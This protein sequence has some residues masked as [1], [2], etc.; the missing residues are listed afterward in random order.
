MR[1]RIR[2]LSETEKTAKVS[3]EVQQLRNFEESLLSNYKAYIA[4]LIKVI[5]TSRKD[6]R[7]A[8]L[9]LVA[10]TCVTSLLTNVPHFNFRTD[11]LK[12]I[13]SELSRRT[14]SEAFTKSREALETLFNEDENGNASLE[15]V[16]MLS[17]MIK[18]RN[19]RVHPTVISSLL[20]LRLLSELG[21]KASTDS[22]DKPKLSKKD[23]VFRTKK[24][25]KRLKEQKKVEK[26]MAEADAQVS[27]EE[28]ERLQS[29]TLKIVFSLYF[30]TLKE[31]KEDAMLSVVLD[32]IAKF[33]RLINAEFFGDLLEVLREILEG[34]DDEDAPHKPR[35]TRLRDELVCLNTAFTLLANQGESRIDLSFF[36]D[37]FYDLLLEISL[38]PI[39]LVKPSNEER[40]LIE[41]VVRI[42]DAILFNPPTA[43]P[44][45]RILLF[46]KRLLTCALH[47]E[48][49]EAATFMK[50][51]QR[52]GRRFEKKI[53]GMWD[54]EGAGLGDSKTGRGIR[55]WE[56]ALLGKYYNSNIRQAGGKI[57]RSDPGTA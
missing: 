38:S 52:I 42:V 49:K 2:P 3:K 20:H 54:T 32:G 46:Y 8:S 34:W 55:G 30:R 13:V 26:D 36:I 28:R 14:V 43:P 5:K 37:R 33:A 10:I 47:M 23:R 57:W 41:L 45:A 44:P 27:T 48:E 7:L 9:S 35:R 11:L 15:A 17:K 40:S 29:E 53:E 31:T 39:L 6:D 24:E 56:L 1:Y 19:Y 21:V 51:I 12:V 50:L 4:S 18:S 16:S 25:R 22:V